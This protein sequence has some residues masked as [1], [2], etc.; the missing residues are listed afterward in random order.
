MGAYNV[1]DMALFLVS[2]VLWHDVEA[3]LESSSGAMNCLF[4]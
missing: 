4:F 1:K 2:L 3:T